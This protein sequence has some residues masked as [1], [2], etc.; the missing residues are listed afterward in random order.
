MANQYLSDELGNPA[1]GEISIIGGGDARHAVTVS[2]LV[3]GEL[4]RVGNGLGMIASG[5]VTAVAPAEF[6]FEV[7]TIETIE[8]PTPAIWLAQA[9]AKG[10]RDELA[11]QASTELGVD[12]IIPWTAARSISRWEGAKIAKGHERWSAVVR[13]ATKQSARAWLPEVASLVNTKQLAE[14]AETTRMIVL[15]PVADASVTVIAPDFHDIVLVVG[16]E[17]GISPAEFDLLH[18]AGATSARLGGSIL[19]TSTAGPAAIAVLSAKLGR[20]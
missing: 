7:E 14:L 6:R 13:E 18:S 11:I 15:D 8:R 5:T 1:I 17:G 19:R 9:L 3:V 20:W 12:G 2:R 10:D 16:P 4:V